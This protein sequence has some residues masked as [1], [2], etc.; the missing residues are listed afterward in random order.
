[1]RRYDFPL[2]KLLELRSHKEREAAFKLAEVTGRYVSAENEIS[3][4]EK[5]MRHIFSDRYKNGIDINMLINDEIRI[6]G[7]K[8]RTAVLKKKLE[9]IKKEREKI[10]LD[11]VE[12]LKNKKVMEKLKEKKRSEFMKEELRKEYKEA[13]DI[14]ETGIEEIGR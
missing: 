8:N 6:S 4:L 12:A 13:E 11:Y 2:E 3:D 14:A 9:E 1:M 7:I 5:R 10:R